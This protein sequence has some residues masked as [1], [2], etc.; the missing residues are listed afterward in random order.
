M[1]VRKSSLAR[2]KR[3]KVPKKAKKNDM[4]NPNRIKKAIIKWKGKWITDETRITVI[5]CTSLPLE[6][7]K[8]D[9]KKFFDRSIYFPFHDYTTCRMLWKTII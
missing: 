4:S 5:G 3:A 8:K 2:R 6:G 1:S 7:S 9:F